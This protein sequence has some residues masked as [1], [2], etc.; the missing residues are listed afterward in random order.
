MSKPAEKSENPL[1]D[2]KIE[3]KVLKTHAYSTPWDAPIYEEKVVSNQKYSKIESVFEIPYFRNPPSYKSGDFWERFN[4][5]VERKK[6]LKQT[7]DDITKRYDDIMVVFNKELDKT[8]AGNPTQ[9]QKDRMKE[10]II[11]MM[12]VY[13][14]SREVEHYD[15]IFKKEVADNKMTFNEEEKEKYDDGMA[16]LSKG[17]P[18]QLT[19]AYQKLNDNFRKIINR[20]FLEKNMRFYKPKEIQDV[21]E[22]KERLM[23][24]T[25]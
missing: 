6:N 19:V 7:L 18:F 1:L 17:F 20:F 21:V 25:N 5:C 22:Y 11:Q 24:K 8:F 2:K 16:I 3:R 4:M 13:H 14:E 12:T 23:Y 10:Y 15:D 9:E